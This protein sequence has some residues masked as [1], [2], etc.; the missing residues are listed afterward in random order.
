[1]GAFQYTALDDRGHRRKGILDGDTA[2]TVRAQLRNRGLV[3]LDV[4]ETAARERR[5]TQFGFQR[6]ISTI[7]LALIVRQ[8]ATLINSGLPLDESLKTV[9]EQTEKD[10]LANIIAAVRTRVMEGHSLAEA[11]ASFPHIFPEIFRATV[12]AGEQTGH[13]GPVLERLAD[14]A[15]T[16]QQIQQKLSLALLYP[17]ILIGISTIIVSA[18][19]IY[20]VPKVVT[21]FD[22]INAQLPLLTRILISTSDFLRDYWAGLLFLLAVTALGIRQLLSM[23]EPRRRW[24]YFLLRLPLVGRIVRGMNTAR[25]TR[26]LSILAGSGV[27]VLEALRISGEVITNLPMRSAVSAAALRVR[28]G[29]A[30]NRALKESGLFPPMTVHLIASGEA[31]G[32]LDAM[33][34]RAATNQEREMDTLIAAML[35]ILEPVMILLM[36]IVVLTI[37]LAILMPIF[38]LNDL[39]RL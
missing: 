26:T 20:V 15:E 32:Q 16:R 13:L 27:P 4:Q 21:V 22:S 35:G 11:L 19:L 33:L 38:E 36:G 9:T 24:H 14:Y 23:P 28:E 6:G 3:P 2:K 1:M 37:V 25:F 17:F 7:D 5:P 8:L 29:T 39:V 30:I 10:R 31:S 34:E 18:L 12:A